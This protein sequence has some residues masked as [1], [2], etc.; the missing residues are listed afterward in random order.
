VRQVGT[1]QARDGALS[2]DAFGQ[3]TLAGRTEA[4]TGAVAISSS[5]SID[6][7]AAQ[8]HASTL[9][10]LQ[11]QGHL[12]LAGSS[13]V[14]GGDVYASA[15]GNL[16]AGPGTLLEATRSMDLAGNTELT[17][18]AARITAGTDVTL[19]ATGDLTLAPQMTE[20]DTP[21]SGGMR[22]DKRYARTDITASGG[23]TATSSQGLLTLDGAQVVANG[24]GVALQGANVVLLARKD[25]TEENTVSGGWTRRPSAETPVGVRVWADGAVSVL[26]RALTK[27][28]CLPPAR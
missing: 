11:A 7:S 23:F 14:T 2:I 17:L 4:T 20:T 6:A 25:L 24:G 9:A 16:V 22:T 18:Q 8:V 10:L 13:R 5:G 3:V 1:L 27:A 21:I 26:A 15:G 28:N 12:T 19:S